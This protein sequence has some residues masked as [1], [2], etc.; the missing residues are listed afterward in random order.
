M[1]G[2][3]TKRALTILATLSLFAFAATNFA[4]GEEQ[5]PTTEEILA[6]HEELSALEYANKETFTFEIPPGT[7][8]VFVFDWETHD[9]HLDLGPQTAGDTPSADCLF[10]SDQQ[11]PLYT[12]ESTSLNDCP[13][14]SHNWPIGET[15]LACVDIG[16]TCSITA[17]DVNWYENFLLECSTPLIAV[18]SWPGEPEPMVGECTFQWNAFLTGELNPTIWGAWLSQCGS[19]GTAGLN[20]CEHDVYLG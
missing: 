10:T 2:K 4:L 8:P 17:S 5:T 14:V 13:L 11:V 9:M 6:V 20:Y 15:T 16:A 12:G 3:T 19:D 7:S 18:T 1:F